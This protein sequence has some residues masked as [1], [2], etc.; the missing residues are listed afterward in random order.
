M[1]IP[2]DPM[3]KMSSGVGSLV[4]ALRVVER[5]DAPLAADEELAH[6]VREHDD[7]PERQ[8]RGDPPLGRALATFVFGLE[9]HAQPTS[10]SLV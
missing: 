9:E 1:I 8:E 10:A 3:V 4:L 2:T 7:V 5:G 6:H